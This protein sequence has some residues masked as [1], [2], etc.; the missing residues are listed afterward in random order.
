MQKAREALKKK[1]L[2][3]ASLPVELQ[4]K[5]MTHARSS[6]V[7]SFAISH[8]KS[9]GTYAELRSKLGCGPAYSDKR[10]RVVRDILCEAIIPDSEEEALK[11]SQ[12]VGNYLKC[13]LEELV[14][15]IDDEI[16]SLGN[17]EVDTKVRPNYYK[18]KMDG[19]KALLDEN[20]ESLSSYFDMKKV[21]ANER[22]TQ[23][24]SIVVNNNYHIA[25]PGDNAKVVEEAEEIKE[26]E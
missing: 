7:I 24:V 5:D 23:G 9:G 21:K 22:K 14:Q 19:I 15:E 2:A 26:I 13:Q 17:R 16:K 25:R 12:T 1:Q 18:L 6:E 4:V 3:A 20:Q 8:L 11:A 10:W